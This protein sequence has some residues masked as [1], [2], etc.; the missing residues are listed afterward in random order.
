MVI[1][2]NEVNKNTTFDEYY[3][4]NIFFL[5]NLVKGK[6]YYCKSGFWYIKMNNDSIPIITF[7]TPRC[8]YEWLVMSFGLKNA[9]QI[10]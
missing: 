7:S 9:P 3:I 2:Y 1:N 10:F 4:P 8:H 5:I 6:N